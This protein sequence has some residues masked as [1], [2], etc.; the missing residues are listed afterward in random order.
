MIH[1]YER[2]RRIDEARSRDA[3]R[4]LLDL[5]IT[6]YPTLPLLD[7]AWTLRHNFSAYDA[8]YVALA[9]A[10]ETSVVTADAPLAR[11]ISDHST[12]RAILL[13]AEA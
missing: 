5:P 6:R 9:E 11:A 10:L 7:R 3:A 13:A 12:A 2:A 8:M 4:A 1:V